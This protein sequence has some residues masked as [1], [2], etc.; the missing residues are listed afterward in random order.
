M[1][2]FIAGELS[3]EARKELERIIK[4]I[5]QKDLIKAKFIEPENLHL[6]LK[7]LGEISDFKLNHVRET[8]KHLRFGKIKAK[9]GKLGVFSPSYVKILWVGLEPEE[10]FKE[11][12]GK[13]NK[14]LG[15]EEKRRFSSHVTLARVKSVKNRKMFLESLKEIKVEPV[16]FLVDKIKLKK[17]TLT[18]KGPLYEDILKVNL[19]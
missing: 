9:L 5:R 18:K 11:L 13:I 14:L 17:S 3:A 1:R 12:A 10:K 15:E 4:E 2:V 16:E 8:L 19:E 6:T 7:F